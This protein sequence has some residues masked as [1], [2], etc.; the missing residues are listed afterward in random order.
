MT[1]FLRNTDPCTRCPDARPGK[2][3][4]AA[5]TLGCCA[6]CWL[7]ASEEQRAV[8]KARYEGVF[9]GTPATPDQVLDAWVIARFQSELERTVGV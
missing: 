4:R 9:F 7:G 1:S 6:L 8:A 3:A 5:V 2:P